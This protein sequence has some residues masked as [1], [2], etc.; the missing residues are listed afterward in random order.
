MTNHYT[1]PEPMHEKTRQ[2]IAELDVF[3]RRQP[4]TYEQAFAKAWSTGPPVLTEIAAIRELDSQIRVQDARYVWRPSHEFPTSHWDRGGLRAPGA[5]RAG[6]DG[7]LRAE[8]PPGSDH[9]PAP[10]EARVPLF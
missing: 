8:A 3:R 9:L 4:S 5:D 10:G 2:A 1:V 6:A 7:S